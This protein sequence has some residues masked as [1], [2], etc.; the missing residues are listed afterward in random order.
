MRVTLNLS[1]E[2]EAGLLSRAQESGLAL[3][4]YLL[5][6][7]EEVAMPSVKQEAASPDEARKEA[8]RRM[9][10]F[11]EKHQLSLGEPITRR[12]LHEKHRF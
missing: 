11:G 8:V 5:T 6:I 7:V 1:P 12:L 2:I 9:I 10:E 4:E 3:E